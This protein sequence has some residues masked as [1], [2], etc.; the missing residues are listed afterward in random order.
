MKRNG[1]VIVLLL[2]L[3]LALAACAPSLVG[4]WASE[5]EPENAIE[6]LQ[7]GTVNAYQSDTLFGTG[8]YEIDGDKI[9]MTIAGQSAT[10]TFK[11]EGNK[12]TL[13]GTNPDG[14]EYTTILIRQ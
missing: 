4:K 9:T 13:T 2:I 10:S 1:P 12:L 5:D 8:A 7:D 14:S 3:S 11:L 6:F